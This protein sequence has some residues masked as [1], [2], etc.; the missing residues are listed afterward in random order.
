MINIKKCLMFITIFLL[1]FQESIQRVAPI[2]VIDYFDELF[3]IIC[4]IIAF[5]KILHTKTINKQIVILFLLLIGFFA[6]GT[7]S[8]YKNS[9]YEFSKFLESSFL[10]IKSFLL[11]L[12]ISIIGYSDEAKK[13]FINI[14]NNIGI[15]CAVVAVVNFL[16]PN[17]Y[18][19]IF[20]F[21]II[22]YRFGFVSV[23]SLFYHP[24]RYGWFMLLLSIMNYVIY[25][26]NGKKKYKNMF[27]TF[28]LF[29][30]LSFRTKVI[31]SIIVIL[32]FNVILSQKIDIKKIFTAGL[33]GLIIFTIFN[34]V[35]MNTYYL[36]FDDNNT[37]ISARQS[38]TN[39]S[40]RIL[41]DYF[42]LG[43]GFGKYGS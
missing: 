14:M 1:L 25:K 10:A 9:S 23:T 24:G 33:L 3:V 30:L 5:G 42:P 34:N 11:I 21:G 18:I 32:I 13:Q 40:I 12:D 19:K 38:L 31:L 35:I 17:I 15:I 28:G 41:K 26:N 22:T 43:V 20:P 36:Y 29:S 8:L 4:T 27:F 7:I 16:F 2:S 6:T 39:N 37:T